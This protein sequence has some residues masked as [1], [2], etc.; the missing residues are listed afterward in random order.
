[1]KIDE[2]KQQL[3]NAKADFYPRDRNGW[4]VVRGESVFFEDEDGNIDF[5]IL[6]TVV[7]P[8]TFKNDRESIFYWG[9]NEK[10]DW[11]KDKDVEFYSRETTVIRT[12][13]N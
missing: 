7:H 2:I 13:G 6:T 3:E 10:D 1:M 5:D 11:I 12:N 9:R 4:G 8:I